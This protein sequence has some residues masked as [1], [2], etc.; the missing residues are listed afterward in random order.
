M[1]PAKISDRQTSKEKF[2]RGLNGRIKALA[3][4]AVMDRKMSKVAVKYSRAPA[5]GALTTCFSLLVQFPPPV[6]FSIVFI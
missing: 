3:R 1:Q 5:Y 6:M 4:S 2:L